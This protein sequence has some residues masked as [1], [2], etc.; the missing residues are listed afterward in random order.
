MKNVSAIV[1]LMFT[2]MSWAASRSMAVERIARP[3]VV[4]ATNADRASI[5]TSERTI[6]NRLR[7]LITIGPIVSGSFDRTWGT[8]TIELL[9]VT[10]MMFWRMKLTPMAVISGARRGALRSGR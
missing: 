7:S 5:S 8:V 1:L 3:R 9:M 4:R 10:K 2:P 6:T